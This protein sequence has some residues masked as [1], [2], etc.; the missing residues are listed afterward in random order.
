MMQVK[1][2]ANCSW[3][4]L[5]QKQNGEAGDINNSTWCNYNR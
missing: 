5:E 3:A 4:W 2:T 1:Q